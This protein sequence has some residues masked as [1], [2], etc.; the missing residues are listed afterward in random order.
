MQRWQSAR[1]RSLSR[2]LTAIY[3]EHIIDVENGE[4][5]EDDLFERVTG[6][7]KCTTTVTIDGD[8][9]E[10][11]RELAELDDRSVSYYTN[12]LLKYH[13]SKQKVK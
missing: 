9:L 12:R 11:I 13:L 1:D 4:V 8:V 10:K 6:V 7:E 3:K 5:I 2:Y